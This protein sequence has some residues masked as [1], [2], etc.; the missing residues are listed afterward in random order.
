MYY[1]CPKKA[2]I[3][4]QGHQPNQFNDLLGKPTIQTLNLPFLLYVKNSF[5]I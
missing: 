5:Y 3:P 1:F 2:G 4:S